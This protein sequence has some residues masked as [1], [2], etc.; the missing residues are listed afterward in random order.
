VEA[1]ALLSRRIPGA[2]AR[3]K[4]LGIRVPRI[5]LNVVQ[6]ILF[7]LSMTAGS[8]IYVQSRSAVVRERYL[9]EEA[10]REQS[11]IQMENRTLRLTWATLTSPKILDDMARRRFRLH[12][13]KPQEV[14]RLP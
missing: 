12:N 13:P 1:V 2:R 10:Q 5:A 14:V 8:L 9:L 6:C 3:G 11:R 4:L 7:I